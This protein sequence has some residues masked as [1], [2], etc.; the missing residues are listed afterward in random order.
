VS[1][2]AFVPT[3]ENVFQ[4]ESINGEHKVHATSIRCP[5]C[6]ELGSFE[7]LGSKGWTFTKSGVVGPNRVGMLFFASLRICPN[8]ACKGLIFTIEAQNTIWKV[9]PP[10]LLDFNIDNLPSI[11]Q[12]T[13]KEAVACHGAGAY[14]AAAMMVRRLLEEIC[15]L[16]QAQGKNLHERLKT[17]RKSIIL[18]EVLFNA[19]DELKALGND[20]AHIEAK[21][22]DTI[23][24]EEAEDSIELAK[25]I[26][27]S[28]YQLQGLVARLQAKK[29]KTV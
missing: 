7:A 17:L 16:N 1:N 20:A 18:P 5:H 26:L 3:N 11:C 14:R 27:K 12:E 2:S 19:M 22:F 6:R 24:R 10:Q 21:A 8:M 15:E 23:G 28:L 29:N 13:L 4:V 25:E 9:E